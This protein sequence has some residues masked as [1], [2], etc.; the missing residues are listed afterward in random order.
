[1]LSIVGRLGS[2]PE[3]APPIAE[4]STITGSDMVNNLRLTLGCFQIYNSNC[5]VSR[6]S[7]V[8]EVGGSGVMKRLASARAALFGVFCVVGIFFLVQPASAVT[9]NPGDT[10]FLDFGLPELGSPSLVTVSLTFDTSPTGLSLLYGNSEQPLTGDSAT[11]SISGPAGH[12]GFSLMNSTA[13]AFNLIEATATIDGGSMV[14]E[15][16]VTVTPAPPSLVLFLTGALLLFGFVN[17]RRLSG[18]VE[19]LAV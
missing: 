14:Y 7:H 18:F 5:G 6:P 9:V 4:N 16:A 10:A 19:R 12:Y 8:C 1:M 15:D 13:T 2:L 17:R 11:F 3:I